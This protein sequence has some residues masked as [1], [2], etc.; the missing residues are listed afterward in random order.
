LL[1][2]DLW[3]FWA[4]PLRL[5]HLVFT[6]GFGQGWEYAALSHFRE[7]LNAR[8]RALIAS[9]RESVKRRGRTLAACLL[10]VLIGGGSAVLWH[11]FSGSLSEPAVSKTDEISQL[12]STLKGLQQS[13][14]DIALDVRHDEQM[15]QAQQ[16]N[17]KRL[18][19]QI[20]QLAAKLDSLQSS[21]RDAQASAP[22]SVQKTAPK[23]PASKPVVHEPASQAPASVTPEEKQ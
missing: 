9:T 12:T 22:P 20:F 7:D 18:S 14:Q 17:I 15:L 3:E 21:L 5:P 6:Y 13:Q 8:A 11:Y 1:F 23:K 10:L 19:D 2:V 16:A 4:Q